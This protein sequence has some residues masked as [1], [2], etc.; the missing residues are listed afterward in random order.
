MAS[1]SLARV[2]YFH[3]FVLCKHRRALLKT[4]SK[5]CS[6]PVSL[7]AFSG[8]LLS[9]LICRKYV[10][11]YKS[12]VMA[13]CGS[14]DSI[15]SMYPWYFISWMKTFLEKKWYCPW[16][17]SWAVSH[18]AK[19]ASICSFEQSLPKPRI[20]L[21]EA[22]CNPFQNYTNNSGKVWLE[23]YS[24]HVLMLYRLCSLNSFYPYP[25]PVWGRRGWG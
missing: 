2:F 17:F 9:T 3:S 22:A 21:K 25:P 8:V 16:L 6:F 18:K 11:G 14:R 23:N 15:D 12:L 1:N 13:N 24:I 10:F 5:L 20:I 19:H 7:L 4:R